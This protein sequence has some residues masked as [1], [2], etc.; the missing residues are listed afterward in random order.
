[1][2]EQKAELRKT[3]TQILKRKNTMTSE[4]PDSLLEG[5]S[6]YFQKES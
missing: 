3:L 5:M 2:K 4:G 1:M 6:D